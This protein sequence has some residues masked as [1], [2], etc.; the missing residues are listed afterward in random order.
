MPSSPKP[1]RSIPGTRS[2]SPANRNLP[3]KNDSTAH[4]VG[5]QWANAKTV[6][7]AS[8]AKEASRNEVLKDQANARNRSTA[9]KKSG[10]K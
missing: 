4:A 7:R 9:G 10:R 5:K 8:K 3:N 2:T 6:T 1:K